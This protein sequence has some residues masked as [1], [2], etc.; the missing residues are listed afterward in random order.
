[1]KLCSL[2]GHTSYMALSVPGNLSNF[3]ASRQQVEQRNSIT[4]TKVERGPGDIG[5]GQKEITMEEQNNT[6]FIYF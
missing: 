5:L 6:Q 3:N 2:S 1:M 4:C